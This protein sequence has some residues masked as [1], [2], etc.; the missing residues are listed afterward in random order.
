[1]SMSCVAFFIRDVFFRVP[2]ALSNHI[3]LSN[4]HETEQPDKLLSRSCR[5]IDGQASTEQQH[6]QTHPIIFNDLHLSI[7][8]NESMTFR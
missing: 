1:M 6:K 3:E 4:H 5:Q 8:R 7:L 2:A